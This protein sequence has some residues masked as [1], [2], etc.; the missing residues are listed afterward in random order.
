MMDRLTQTAIAR[1][2]QQAENVLAFRATLFD[3]RVAR[4]STVAEEL[5]AFRREEEAAP[6]DASLVRAAGGTVSRGVLIAEGDSWFDYPWF[7]V[8]GFLED[9]HHYDVRSVAHRADTIEGMAYSGGQLAN[10]S[11]ELEKLIR[12]GRI[13]RAI[14]LSGGGIDVAGLEFQMLLAHRRSPQPGLNQQVVSGIIDER[15][16]FAYITIISAVTQISEERTG[17]RIPILVHGYDYP[18]PDGRGYLG[19]FSVLPGPWLEPGFRMKDYTSLDERKMWARELI[20]RFNAMLERLQTIV[21][22]SHVRYVNLL[23]TL[24][25]EDANYKDWWD[26]EL[27]P[28][29]R[30]FVAVTDKIA[31]ELTTLL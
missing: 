2:Q 10:F 20:T 24:S 15:V 28:T 6:L 16:R 30:G 1:G 7:D 23:G 11:R 13:P 27:H 8:L 26:N 14:L 25:D 21:E 9:L 22:Y 18:V 29:Q 31:H 19:G 5:E 4:A 12:Q 3:E 17:Q